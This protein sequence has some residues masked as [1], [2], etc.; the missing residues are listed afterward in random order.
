MG[1]M[2]ILSVLYSLVEPILLLMHVRAKLL[3][4][5]SDSLR[6]HGL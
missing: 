6:P 2:K 1:R 3:Q 4:F 5:V